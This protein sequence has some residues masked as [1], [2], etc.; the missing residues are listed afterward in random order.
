MQGKII[1]E[2]TKICEKEEIT[3]ENVLSWAK[4]VKVQRVQST[5]MNSLIEVKEFDKLKVVK[6]TCN[7]SPRRY[8]QTKMPTKQTCRYCGSSHSQRQCPA[9]GKSCTDCSKIGHFRAVC[10]C[11]RTLPVN[12][13]EKEAAQD[14]T[15]DYSIDS[16]NI[17]SI[18][19]NRYH[20]VLTANL[21][22]FTGPHNVIV[23]YTVD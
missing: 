11:R 10:R 8:M 19:F 16:V 18:H 12:E 4:R 2:L 5:I 13:V 17:N 9:Y 20:S 22:M 14:S 1:K 3:G 15:E 23:P 21:K 7:G 6:S